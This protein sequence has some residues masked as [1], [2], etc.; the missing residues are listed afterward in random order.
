MMQQIIILS[1]ALGRCEAQQ[2]LDRENRKFIINQ[3]KTSALANK[4]VNSDDLC[5][6]LEE[7]IQKQFKF[8]NSEVTPY[9]AKQSI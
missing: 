8:Q 9:R 7:K 1:G 3:C 5:I 4:L 2:R 6:C